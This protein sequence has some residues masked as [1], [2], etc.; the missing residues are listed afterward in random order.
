MNFHQLEIR[1]RDRQTRRVLTS[2]DAQV[3]LVWNGQRKFLDYDPADDG[4]VGGD[5]E[6]G[7]YDLCIARPATDIEQH[8]VQVDP[9]PTTITLSTGPES[10]TGDVA[11]D[12]YLLGVLPR[13]AVA[14]SR[15]AL[16]RLTESAMSLGL[17]PVTR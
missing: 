15:E 13:P 7:L 9:A 11:G 1:I 5:I 3:Y 6:P 12:N 17:K 8:Q 10:L 16:D 4:F 2:K 14:A